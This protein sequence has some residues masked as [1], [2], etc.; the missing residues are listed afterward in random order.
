M[1]AGAEPVLSTIFSDNYGILRLSPQAEMSGAK[2][3]QDRGHSVGRKP[4]RSRE[5]SEYGLVFYTELF[6]ELG[7]SKTGRFFK[8]FDKVREV[9]ETGFDTDSRYFHL[10]FKQ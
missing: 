8:A 4:R 2:K 10:I 1:Y 3:A 9:L 7:R 6:L 5:E